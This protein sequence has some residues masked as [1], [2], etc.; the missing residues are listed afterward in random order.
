MR[1]NASS[2][3]R[4]SLRSRSRVRSSRLNS[5]SW[6]ARSLGSGKFAASSFMCV[7]VRSTSTMRSRFQ[8][9]R[10]KR[11]CSSCCLLMYCSPRLTM[12]GCTLR[13][14]ASRLPGSMVS[15]SSPSA[16]TAGAAA[17]R[18]AVIIVAVAGGGAVAAPARSGFLG[19]TGGSPPVAG[20]AARGFFGAPTGLRACATAALTRSGSGLRPT[21]FLTAGRLAAFLPF[22]DLG[23][24]L[25]A[26]INGSSKR[27]QPREETR[28]YTGRPRAVQVFWQWLRQRD[29]GRRLPAVLSSLGDNG[30]VDSAA[31]VEARRQPQEARLQCGLQVIGNFVGHGLVIHAAITKR[32]D[33]Q[34]H[35]FQFHAQPVGHVLEIEPRK[36]RLPGARTQAGELGDLHADRVITSGCGV[37]ERL[38]LR[39]GRLGHIP[40]HYT[41]LGTDQGRKKVRCG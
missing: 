17:E 29:G 38:E 33:V 28:D 19:S 30:R 24:G 5:S 13:G 20:T 12:Y 36:V 21:A 3:L 32:P 35:G 10:M 6:V 25:L 15:P 8:L 18:F 39:Y 2:I 4:I 16:F 41:I 1:F 22:A 26:G 27:H 31:H 34:L 40:L 7:T 14:P 23:A 11:K 9:L 37:G